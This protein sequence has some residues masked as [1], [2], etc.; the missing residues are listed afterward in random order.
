MATRSPARTPNDKRCVE[1]CETSESSSAYEMCLSA[2]RAVSS[3][4]WPAVSTRTAGTL[5][6]SA[7][8]ARCSRIQIHARPILS[9]N[10]LLR[11][12]VD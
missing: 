6:R 3:G 12:F 1:A 9:L 4:R 8:R 5:P 11:R 2:M 10:R 7:G